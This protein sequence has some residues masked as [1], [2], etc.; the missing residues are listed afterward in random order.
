MT[1]VAVLRPSEAQEVQRLRRALET[2]E[3]DLQAV[4]K[5]LRAERRKTARLQRDLDEKY[6]TSPNYK[7]AEQIFDFW[8]DKTGHTDAKFLRTRQKT[9]LAALKNYTPRECC[10]AVLGCVHLGFTAPD[11]KQKYDELAVILRD[12]TKIEKN[13]ERYQI[14]CQA[15]GQPFDRERK[16]PTASEETVGRENP[17]GRSSDES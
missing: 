8:R 10:M 14:H 11:T 17:A 7:T 6:R 2:T 1:N 4:E 13:I 15:T 5:A 3:T 9:V 12:E 16:R